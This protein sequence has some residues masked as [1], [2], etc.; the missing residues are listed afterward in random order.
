MA[1]I[2]TG[3][4][5]TSRIL[6]P[7]WSVQS[8]G[9]GLVTISATYLADQGSAETTVNVAGESFEHFSYGYCTAHK[10]SIVYNNLGIAT[11]RI[12][13]VGI[14]PEV[15]SGNVTNANTSAANGLTS[16]NI[17]AHPNFFVAAAGY[18][19]G[20]I[21]GESPY[22]ED[23]AGEYAPLVKAGTH[24]FMGLNGSCFE[25]ATGGRFIGFV[26]PSYPH[27]YGK[28]QYLSRVTSYSGVIYVSDS[29][30]VEVLVSLN[31]TSST[32]DA[33]STFTLLP[34]WAP[35]GAG[36]L[37]DPVNLLSQINVEQ[38]GLIYKVNYEIRYSKQGWPLEV[39]AG[40]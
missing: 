2:E 32:T 4:E 37:G 8:D 39:Y 25:T 18:S 33:W 21:A 27:F 11:I 40:D 12:D 36:P 22:E 29:A 10:A 26:D 14:D 23:T 19:G 13:Y 3:D 6:Q 17:T 5:L 31:G 16:E 35:L 30:G 7:G 1:R 15:N 34:S 24:G 9:F 20:A 38:F 28:T